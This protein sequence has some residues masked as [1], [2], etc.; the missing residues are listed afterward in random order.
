MPSF[1][2]QAAENFNGIGQA[3]VDQ[4]QPVSPDPPGAPMTPEVQPFVSGRLGPEDIKGELSI[5]LTDVEG[6]PTGIRFSAEG[7]LYEV[8]GAGFAQLERVVSGIHR[9]RAWRTAVSYDSLF[10]SV[11][12][13]L[14]LLLCSPIGRDT[15]REV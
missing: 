6:R 14:R 7:R 10:A 12:E 13:W 9:L 3:L 2:S 8:G 11:I 15:F 4:V 1:H 5:T